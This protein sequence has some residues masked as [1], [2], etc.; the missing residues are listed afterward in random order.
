M[1]ET[2]PKE[3]QILV[4]GFYCAY[5]SAFA[6]KD[7]TTKDGR[8][9]GLF[10]GFARNLIDIH[11]RWP[12][13]DVVVCWDS[14]S[15]WRREVY[16]GYKANR[17]GSKGA[18]DAS[19]MRAVAHFCS[20]VGVTQALAPGHEADDVVGSLVDRNRLNIIYS[21]D[22]DFCQLVEDGVVEVYSPKT[23]SNPEVV[24]TE[25]VV[26][27]KFGVHPTKL[28]LY[29]A[30]RGDSSDNLP[31]LRRFPSK[32]IIALVEKHDDI[33]ELL[34]KPDP[35][36]KLTEYQQK[37]LV[38][39]REQ[40]PINYRLMRI[41]TDLE[42]RRITSG[43]QRRRATAL[44]DEFELKSLKSQLRCFDEQEE[45]FMGFFGS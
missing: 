23:G 22:R 6:F 32:K 28:L 16:A 39:F 30:L 20:H 33:N 5:R 15:T 14:K 3:T 12:G 26:Q 37:A 10:F 11:K 8:P 19:Q 18:R 2:E 29:R 31:G 7:L 13:A 27:A 42:V 38:D 17:S 25:G 36:V 45:G 43:F 9:S 40:G 44:L 35:S 4:D 21:R 24:Y 41:R 34:T 1:T